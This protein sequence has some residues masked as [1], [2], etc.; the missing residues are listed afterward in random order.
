MARL[1]K[2]RNQHKIAS[3]VDHA[4][5]LTKGRVLQSKPGIAM[6]SYTQSTA[7]LAIVLFM[8]ARPRTPGRPL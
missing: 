7:T 5:V 2:R 6:F 8:Q 4:A 1:E 3:V